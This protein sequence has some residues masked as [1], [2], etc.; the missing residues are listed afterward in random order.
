M[1]DTDRQL[2]DSAEFRGLVKRGLKAGSTE[3]AGFSVI[4][5]RGRLLKALGDP[6]KREVGY[7]ISD[8]SIDRAG[9]QI[10]QA[11]WNVDEWKQN[12][13]VLL[14]HDSFSG[15]PIAKGVS[16]AIEPHRTLSVAAFA[17]AATYDLAD[18]VYKLVV[19]GFMGAASV[20]FAPDEWTMLEDNGIRF[21]QQTLLEYSVVS[22]PCNANALMSAS[23]KGISTAPLKAWAEEMLEDVKSAKGSVARRWRSELAVLRTVVDPTKGVSVPV[24]RPNR[25]DAPP[26]SDLAAVAVSMDELLR[27]VGVLCTTAADAVAALR[28]P[29]LPGA[30]PDAVPLTTIAQA[31]TDA[32]KVLVN[33]AALAV[34]AGGTPAKAIGVSAAHRPALIRARAALRSLQHVKSGR[35][36]SAQNEAA[37]RRAIA[38][39]DAVLAQLD[40]AP[41]DDKNVLVLDDE[42]VLGDI[43]EKELSDIIVK[44]LVDQIT[45][46][47]M[48]LTGKVR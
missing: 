11:G 13:V 37:L 15:L 17:D 3:L 25:K 32:A 26:G 6:A 7:V 1:F 4:V 42:D 18:T 30:D 41:A 2:I 44:I 20:G 33:V 22:L 29:G 40:A 12:P 5:P 27:N 23:A 14:Q 16:I 8:D 9:D 45:E 39:L 43:T 48:L 19:G 24:R 21:E 38:E 36:L 35:V 47:E 46:S 31:A 10:V 28:T 34:A